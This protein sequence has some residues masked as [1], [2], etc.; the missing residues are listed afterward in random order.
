[1]SATL[2]E[3]WREML[4][5]QTQETFQEFW[6]AYSGAETRIYTEIV[7]KPRR[8]L[9]GGVSELAEKFETTDVIF[10]GFLDGINSSLKTPLDVAATTP[11]T[12]IDLKVNFEELYFNMLEAGAD[13]LYNI[14]QWEK[15]LSEEKREEIT[16]RWKKSK[17]VVKEKTP[18]R[19]DPCPC[20]SGLKYK[21][22]CGKNA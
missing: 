1:M 7:S 3:Q 13:Y 20:G 9:K 18:G 6:E 21:K 8:H 11:E 22:C 15:A 10:T 5:N 12:E 4:E 2:F 16:K 19:N 17:T 14:P